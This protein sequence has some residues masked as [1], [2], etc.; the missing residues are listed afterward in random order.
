MTEDPLGEKPYWN[1]TDYLQSLIIS[2]LQ[3]RYLYIQLHPI[4]QLP[5]HNRVWTENGMWCEFL[6]VLLTTASNSHCLEVHK[7]TTKFA[8]KSYNFVLKFVLWLTTM[9]TNELAKF[10]ANLE[11]FKRT[12]ETCLLKVLWNALWQ[13]FYLQCYSDNC[14]ETLTTG[15][16]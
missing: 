10:V 2:L 11:N 16:L 14:F 15:C 13:G 9:Y 1:N 4:K 6:F 7:L 12:S 5:L 3:S 8:T